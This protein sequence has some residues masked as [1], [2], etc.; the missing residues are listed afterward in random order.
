MEPSRRRRADLPRRGFR[1]RPAFI[2]M[3]AQRPADHRQSHR[4]NRGA[5]RLELHH[6]KFWRIFGHRFQSH[7]RSDQRDV[8]R[9]LRC[10]SQRQLRRHRPGGSPISLLAPRRNLGNSSERL[11]RGSQWNLQQHCLPRRGRRAG[12]CPRQSRE[13]PGLRQSSGKCNRALLA[14]VESDRRLHP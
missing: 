12:D 11:R 6:R 4:P 7:R 13:L 9:E 3:E 8:H 10:G 2:S 5:H 1:D 14:D